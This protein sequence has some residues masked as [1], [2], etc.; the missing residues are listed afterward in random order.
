MVYR[1]RNVNRV[2]PA[3][4]LTITEMQGNWAKHLRPVRGFIAHVGAGGEVEAR[5][6]VEPRRR[7]RVTFDVTRAYTT[8]PFGLAKKSV[9]FGAPASMVVHPVELRARGGLLKKLTVRA[10]SGAGAAVR[11]GLGDEFYG[12]REYV[13]GD[14]P[15]QIAWRRSARTGQ[16]VVR[17][18]TT[19]TPRSLWVVIRIPE[20]AE[21]RLVERAIAIAAALARGAFREGA[22][23]G[24]AV[25]ALGVEMRPRADARGLRLIL[26]R[27][28]VL[29]AGEAVAGQGFPTN[30]PGLISNAVV[31]AGEIDRAFGTPGTF[32]VAA[33]N[34]G[35][36]LAG[37]EETARALALLDAVDT[38]AGE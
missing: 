20:S 27:L 1:A 37:G 21:M 23:V 10:M 18:N 12:L 14:N 16:M 38:G 35:D 11:P 25:P 32:H 4:G 2:M 31:H 3:F 26:D 33:G 19:P 22:S 15:R 17:Q 8:F 28:A 7:G 6:E 9:S 36:L 5:V 13:D 29:D 34:P 30:L 24:L